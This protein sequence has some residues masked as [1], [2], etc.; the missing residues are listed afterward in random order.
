MAL[1]NPEMGGF[2]SVKDNGAPQAVEDLVGNLKPDVTQ[3]K[4]YNSSIGWNSRTPPN[5]ASPR[6]A[7]SGV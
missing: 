2:S 5:W 6:S 4:G 7:C 3:A 1:H